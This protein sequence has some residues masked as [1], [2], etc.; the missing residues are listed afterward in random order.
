[1][2]RCS[3]SGSSLL[4]L[5]LQVL[6]Y[7]FARSILLALLLASSILHAVLLVSAVGNDHVIAKRELLAHLVSRNISHCAALRYQTQSC[8]V[9]YSDSINATVRQGH[10]IPPRQTSTHEREA[11]S[12][13]GGHV[14]I[15]SLLCIA[16][17]ILGITITTQSFPFIPCVVTP[18]GISPHMGAFAS[19][20]LLRDLSSQLPSSGARKFASTIV[21]EIDSH[22]NGVASLLLVCFVGSGKGVDYDS[23][24]ASVIAFCLS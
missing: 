2:T 21:K 10:A 8:L 12:S 1:L 5:A 6:R 9:P 15:T 20:I 16:A 4:R 7:L 3:S 22:K 13:K 23:H 24:D 18:A 19:C 14:H 11:Q 17:W